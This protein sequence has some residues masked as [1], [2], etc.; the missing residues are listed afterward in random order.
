MFFIAMRES[1]KIV[2]LEIFESIINFMVSRIVKDSAVKIDEK[3]V[4][5][6]IR[7][8]SFQITAALTPIIFSYI[9]LLLIIYNLYFIK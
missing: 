2:A 9:S 3:L 8:V 5:L 6:Y 4:S 7:F 1:E